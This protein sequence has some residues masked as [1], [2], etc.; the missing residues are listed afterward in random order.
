MVCFKTNR[1]VLR[2]LKLTPRQGTP[3]RVHKRPSDGLRPFSNLRFRKVQ[4]RVWRH[5]HV[6]T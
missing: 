4:S 6:L 2:V 3:M 5:P 1:P